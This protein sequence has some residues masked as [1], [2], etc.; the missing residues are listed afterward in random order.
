MKTNP[1]TR[2][3]RAAAAC[4]V[5]LLCLHALS[6]KATTL[7]NW[8]RA[9]TATQSSTYSAQAVASVGIDGNTAGGWGDASTTH[10]ATA[11]AGDWW[12]VDLKAIKPIGHIHLWF[13]E[14]CC[15]SRDENLRIV[16]F[17]STNV[18]TRVV[19][20]ETNNTAWAGA[21]MIR[22]M[23]FDVDPTVNGQV[24]YVEHMAG[25]PDYV[26]LAEC[27]VFNQKLLA[28]TN[29]ALVANGASATS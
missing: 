17:D 13:R 2:A 29:H 22:D 20:W 6:A 3:L 28:P 5:A 21:G 4:S 12:Q 7:T 27:E 16:I 23:G 10:T 19:M 9:G 18:T 24:V 25:L 1:L 8:A 14:D 26:S 15:A 11:N